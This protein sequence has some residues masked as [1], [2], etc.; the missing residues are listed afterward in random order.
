MLRQCRLLFQTI[1]PKLALLCNLWEPTQPW[2]TWTAGMPA[3]LSATGQL[4]ATSGPGT[5][6]IPPAPPST[7]SWPQQVSNKLKN[8]FFVSLSDNEDQIW[9]LPKTYRLVSNLTQILSTKWQSFSQRNWKLSTFFWTKKYCG[10]RTFMKSTCLQYCFDP[11]QFSK[12]VFQFFFSFVSASG[13]FFS[14]PS[15]CHG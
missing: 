12:W 13:G 15:S 9:I 3:L 7:I 5:L 2:R 11:L 8:I 10:I 4:A 1:V 14:G 6:K